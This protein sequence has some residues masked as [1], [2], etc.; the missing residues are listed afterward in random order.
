MEVEVGFDESQ[1][2][3]DHLSANTTARYNHRRLEKLK[4][5]A[6]NRRDPFEPQGQ[7]DGTLS[8]K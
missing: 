2:L 3:L 1:A 5:L 8:A 4:K 6:R 7:A